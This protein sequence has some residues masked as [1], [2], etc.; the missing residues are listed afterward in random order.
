VCYKC[1]VEK[2]EAMCLHCPE[3]LKDGSQWKFQPQLYYAL[4]YTGYYSSYYSIYYSDIFNKSPG[5]KI[6]RERRVDKF[7]NMPVNPGNDPD[8]Q[9][10][11]DRGA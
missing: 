1:I 7:K 8:V 10:P 2:E 5:I 9:M 6:V 11:A 4:Y 3:S